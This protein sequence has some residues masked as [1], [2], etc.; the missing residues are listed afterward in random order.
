[1]NLISNQKWYVVQ[2]RSRFEKKCFEQL[3]LMGI[4]V[5]LPT[6]K[7]KK[8]W[9]DR[10]KEIET[11][12]FSGYLFVQFEEKEKYTI[13]NTNGIVRFVS[14]SGD[15]AS[16][17]EKQIESLK[18]IEKAESSIEIVEM[19]F[20]EGD[21]VKISSGPLKG[22]EAKIVQFNGKRKLLLNIDAIGKGVLIEIEKT[23]IEK[24]YKNLNLN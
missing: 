10:V 21:E 17:S 23:K 16:V 13:L 9:S 4:N 20:I 15:Y 3:I 8:K 11:P 2:T 6:Q 12:L 19:N 22:L 7:V 1:M 18:N 24:K 5:Y 14:F